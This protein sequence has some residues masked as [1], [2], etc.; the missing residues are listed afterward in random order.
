M[1]TR[2]RRR[3]DRSRGNIEALPSG[4]LRVRVYAGTD[5]VTGRRHDLRGVIPPGPNAETQAEE[6]L[7]R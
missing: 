3:R 1:A 7:A 5:P 4:A 6:T 2:P